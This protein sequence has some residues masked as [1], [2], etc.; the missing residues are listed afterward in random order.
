[1]NVTIAEVAKKAG[2][3][4]ATVSRVLNNSKPV[5]PE[6]RR[7]VIDAISE[8]DFTPN[9]LARSLVNK[10][11]KTIG[12]IVTDVANLF[13]S[14]LVGGVEEVAYSRGYSTLI[15]N[16]QGSSALEVT[17]L[18][19][20]QK[21]H[22]DGIIFL[23]T[24]LRSEH[25]A[26]FK[27]TNLPI[28]LV[29][30]VAGEDSI[31]NVRIDNFRAAYDMTAFFLRRG[32]RRIGMIRAP[33][34]DCFTGRERYHG[35]LQALGEHGVPHDEALVWTGSLE[36]ADGYRVASGIDP[37]SLGLEAI[38]VACDLM[39]F[40]AIKALLE[41]G[42]RVPADLEVAGFDDVPMASFFNPSLTTVRQPI[43]EMGRQA[44]ARLIELVEGNDKGRGELV[45]PHEL[46]FR[47]ST[48]GML[49]PV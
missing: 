46:V 18:R 2:V 36:A 49:A 26:F 12:L 42:L 29:N 20:M 31:I 1:M 22:V 37:R 33:L 6:T 21:K 7:R 39:A 13:V 34:D 25:R 23:T 35:Y 40:G 27:A 8:L 11:S 47:E 19:M 30:V 10:K 14:V 45:L 3:S 9:P 38:F 24:R 43:A 41:K 15:C 48:T 17:L 28:A 4:K 32:F 44:A 5:L 16:S